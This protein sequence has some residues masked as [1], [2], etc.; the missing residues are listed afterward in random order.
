MSEMQYKVDSINLTK[1]ELEEAIKNKDYD[2]IIKS[3]SKVVSKYTAGY[4]EDLKQEIYIKLIDEWINKED[5]LDWKNYLYSRIKLHAK[6]LIKYEYKFKNLS[7]RETDKYI[8]LLSKAK[9]DDEKEELKLL[10]HKLNSHFPLH[11][12]ET[13]D[14]VMDVHGNSYDMEI[15]DHELIDE[16]KSI[17]TDKEF[18]IFYMSSVMGYSVRDIAK[19]YNTSHETISKCIIKCKNTLK[20]DKNIKKFSN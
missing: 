11:H 17:L 9:T 8:K 15:K 13:N 19:K 20:N 10:E 12:Y 6:D 3:F 14:C 1:E 16:I 18:D 5:V 4:G 7:K 2:L